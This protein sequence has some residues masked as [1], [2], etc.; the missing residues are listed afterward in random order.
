MKGLLL[1]QT[2]LSRQATKKRQAQQKCFRQRRGKQKKVY[3][4]EVEGDNMERMQRVQLVS[5]PTQRN[6][7]WDES[8]GQIL[9]VRELLQP[10]PELTD[11]NIEDM[12]DKPLTGGF[13]PEVE[14]WKLGG[15]VMESSKNSQWSPN[16]KTNL[17]GGLTETVQRYCD[18]AW[19]Q[20]WRGLEKKHHKSKNV[21]VNRQRWMDGHCSGLYMKLCAG[22]REERDIKKSHLFQADSEKHS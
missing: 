11:P 19:L 15:L 13:V 7:F 16:S 8:E 4:S 12:I 10:S 14:D 22:E 9:D 17:E 3:T 18:L 5:R 20:D 21:Q 1:A 6:I 2:M